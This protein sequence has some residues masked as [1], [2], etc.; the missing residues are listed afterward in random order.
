MRLVA[1]K[2]SPRPAERPLGR[3]A[4]LRLAKP[5]PLPTPVLWSLRPHVVERPRP[6]LYGIALWIWRVGVLS[7]IVLVTVLIINDIVRQL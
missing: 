3:E 5:N 2:P 6:I 7:G 4:L 1:D